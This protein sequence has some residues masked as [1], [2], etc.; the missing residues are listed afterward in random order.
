[1]KAKKKKIDVR[2]AASFGVDLKPTYTVRDCMW[3]L[4]RSFPFDESV[5][6]LV[7]FY[8]MATS[9]LLSFAFLSHLLAV[10]YLCYIALAFFCIVLA[11]LNYLFFFSLFFLIS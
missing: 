3:V 9:I 4:L 6:W 7:P 2:E 8:D 1:M 10:S 5:F 11:C